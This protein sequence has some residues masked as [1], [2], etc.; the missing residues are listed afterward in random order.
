MNTLL[1]LECMPHMGRDSSYSSQSTVQCLIE[2][3][4]T[5]STGHRALGTDDQAHGTGH[6]ALGMEH[7]TQSTGNIVLDT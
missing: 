4:W 7:W 3:H 6:R 1:T 2:Q 5:Q